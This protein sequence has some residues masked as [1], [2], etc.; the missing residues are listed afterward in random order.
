MDRLFSLDEAIVTRDSGYLTPL[1][2]RLSRALVATM[3]ENE[4]LRE[5]LEHIG[6]NGESY[7]T[8]NGGCD[9]PEYARNTL[10]RSKEYPYNYPNKESV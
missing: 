4:R 10:G 5:A 2:G 6:S 1:E 8:N 9:C 3:H 7:V